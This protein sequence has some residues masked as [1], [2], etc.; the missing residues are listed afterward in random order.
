LES[1]IER[2][3]VAQSK[4]N[5]ALNESI[6]Q[7]NS[8]FDAMASHQKVMDIQIAQIAQQVSHLSQPQGIS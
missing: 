8:K 7:L 5:E 2:F 4:T 6:N 1:L 3:I